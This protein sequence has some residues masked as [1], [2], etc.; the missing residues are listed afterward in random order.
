[1]TLHDRREERGHGQVYRKR[2]LEPP[3]LLQPVCRRDTSLFGTA[4]AAVKTTR[5]TKMTIGP[6]MKGARDLVH[7]PQYYVER[8]MNQGCRVR[9]ACLTY[10]HPATELLGLA[11]VGGGGVPPWLDEDRLRARRGSML[12]QGGC[13]PGGS[14][15]V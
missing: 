8:V 15:A 2:A 10:S 7:K 6:W 5:T 12:E 9:R 1:M 14:L 13:R 4:G 3:E 11:A